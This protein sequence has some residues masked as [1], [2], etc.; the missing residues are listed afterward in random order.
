[1]WD[2][3]SSAPPSYDDSIVTHGQSFINAVTYLPA[4][5]QFSE[6]LI[7]SGGKDTIIEL[8]HP[9]RPPDASAQR[10]L[11]GHQGNVCALDV[12]PDPKT[13][14]LVSGSW[15]ASAIIWDVAKGESIA[16]LEGHSG[17]VWAV[18][19]LDS[20]HVVTGERSDTMSSPDKFPTNLFRMRRS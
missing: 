5:S 14:Y 10:I 16:T 11:L 18:L 7:A 13:P 8:R 1:M 9:G 2:L 15:D 6:P 17:S 12:C 4:S 20:K 19:A 3:Q